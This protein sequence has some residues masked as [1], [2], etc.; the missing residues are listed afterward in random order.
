M[1]S[2]TFT[3][4]PSG[5]TSRAISP[6]SNTACSIV[7][8]SVSMSASTDP[9]RTGSP[10]LTFHLMTVPASIV[11]E[12]RGM[13]SSIGM[14]ISQSCRSLLSVVSSQGPASPSSDP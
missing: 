6:S 13:V 2:P 12:R 7:A 1:T 11:S 3:C 9:E 5:Q 10:S 4:L 14:G 8:L